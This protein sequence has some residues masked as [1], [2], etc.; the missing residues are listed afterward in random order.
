MIPNM[1]AR[2][3]DIGRFRAR[4]WYWLWRCAIGCRRVSANGSSSSFWTGKKW[5][6]LFAYFTKTIGLIDELANPMLE[7]LRLKWITLCLTHYSNIKCI[8]DHFNVVWPW[9]MLFIVFHYSNAPRRFLLIIISVM[10]FHFYLMKLK[11]V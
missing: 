2:S 3:G 1:S 6:I 8:A 9:I 10:C 5:Y 4:E 7:N 11:C